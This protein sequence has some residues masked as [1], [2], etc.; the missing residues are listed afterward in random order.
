MSFI[1]SVPNSRQ[2]EMKKMIIVVIINNHMKYI[3]LLLICFTAFVP[4][5]A[6]ADSY[7]VN[8]FNDNGNLRFDKFIDKIELDSQ[9]DT[10]ENLQ[11][12]VPVPETEYVIRLISSNRDVPSI[13]LPVQPE[14]SDFSK[15]VPYFP[16]TREIQLVRGSE[17][18]DSV[19]VSE[20]LTCN[21]DNVCQY[22]NGENLSTCL[23]DC[24]GSRVTYSEQTQRTLQQ[25]NGVIRDE[26]G[27]VLLGSVA[28]ND[29]T[30]PTNTQDEPSGPSWLL[31]VGGI[32]MIG[33]GIGV[34]L[35]PK[36]KR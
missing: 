15:L 35:Y 24:S 8:L 3:L 11:N 31:L 36:L 18:I 21:S 14:Q 7:V 16:H 13:D 19:D 23:A 10:I 27:T 20:F 26:Q 25:Q 1:H 6:L 4:G 2:R 29:S 22:E 32:V 17:I 12:K 30:T 28:N 34:W 33:L 9:T 5:I